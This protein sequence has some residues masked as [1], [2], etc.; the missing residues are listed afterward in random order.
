MLVEIQQDNNA[1]NP[2]TLSQ[3]NASLVTKLYET[4]SKTT[5]EYLA[6]QDHL[7]ANLMHI[8]DKQAKLIAR[9]AKILHA[10]MF[11]NNFLEIT[12]HCLLKHRKSFLEYGASQ[13][14]R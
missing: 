2:N 13:N 11:I 14:K 1:K 8:K 9:R 10:P 7:I 6:L 12:S 3:N 4:L 5:S